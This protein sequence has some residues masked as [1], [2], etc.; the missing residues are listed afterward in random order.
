MWYY[1]KMKSFK[2]RVLEVVRKI[3]KGKTL[4]YKEVAKRSGHALASRAVGVIMKANDDK[5]VPCHRVIKSDGELG[6]YNGLKGEK[7]KLLKK[8]GALR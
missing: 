2:E 3:P 4:S 6:G 7:L 5:T 1:K 8:E